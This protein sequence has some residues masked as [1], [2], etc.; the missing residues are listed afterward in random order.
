M[1]RSPRR[2][3]P[4]CP[5]VAGRRRRLVFAPPPGSPTGSLRRERLRIS[6]F[7]A[8]AERVRERERAAPPTIAIAIVRAVPTVVTRKVRIVGPPMSPPAPDLPDR[9]GTTRLL[10]SGSVCRAGL[11]AILS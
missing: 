8:D 10:Y 11:G 1:S 2:I 6:L 7:C 3:E 4:L 5:T 9:G